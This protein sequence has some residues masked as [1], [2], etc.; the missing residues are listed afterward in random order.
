ME[1]ILTPGPDAVL[2]IDADHMKYKFGWRFRDS[3]DEE[4][5]RKDIRI[6]ISEILAL[7]GATRCI[8]IFG[9]RNPIREETYKFRKYKGNRPTEKPEWLERWADFIVDF[10]VS[11]LGFIMVQDLE[12]DDVIGFLKKC[13]SP[14]EYII[15][16]PDKDLLQLKGWHVT[17]KETEDFAPALSFVTEE[18]AEKNLFMQ[19]LMGDTT[20]NVAGV[21]KIGEKKAIDLLAPCAGSV[22][23]DIVVHN[24]YKAYFGDHYGTI[25]YAETRYALMACP[26]LGRAEE[27]LVNQGFAG[28]IDCTLFSKM[29]DPVKDPFA[30]LNLPSDL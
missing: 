16:S 30:F 26:E 1:P 8:G 29:S 23:M 25:I 4:S 7:S 20:D 24:T 14:L 3:S 19:Y 5:M 11:E 12:A 21:P 22:E 27:L 9:N 17:L 2:L 18:E 15:A 6:Y 28:L 13:N 10:C